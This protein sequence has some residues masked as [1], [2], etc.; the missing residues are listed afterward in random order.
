MTKQVAVLVGSN[1]TTSVSKIVA[2]YLQSIDPAS[3][4]LNFV[5]ISDLP[6]YDRDLDAQEVA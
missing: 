5:E 6:L 4:Q 1:S 3:I 2:R